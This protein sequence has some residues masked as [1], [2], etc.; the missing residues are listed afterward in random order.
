MGFLWHEGD[1]RKKLVNKM[2]ASKADWICVCDADEVFSENF[3]ELKDSIFNNQNISW[4]AFHA[5][6]LWGDFKHYR[7][8][9]CWGGSTSSWTIKLFKN[10]ADSYSF[11]MG[12]W[13]VRPSPHEVYYLKGERNEQI[14]LFNCGL[15]K[16][17]SWDEKSEARG[18]SYRQV[19]DYNL[20]AVE[21]KEIDE[22]IA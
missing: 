16:P 1:A 10:V 8:D 2:G 3:F 4:C 18:E 11:D 17:N 9:G 5:Y 22:I 6:S 12:N 19:V 13:H 14:K 21:V 7:M 15:S 20:S